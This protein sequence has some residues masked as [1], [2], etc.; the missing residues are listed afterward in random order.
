MVF[1]GRCKI[2]W[3]VSPNDRLNHRVQLKPKRR[4]GPL[5]YAAAAAAVPRDV[6][7]PPAPP[8]RPPPPPP[9][10]PS[11]S[12]SSFCSSFLVSS[13]QRNGIAFIDGH[14]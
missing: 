4:A 6:I 9:P 2:Q 3:P 8:P 5:L 7:R 11:S 13:H 10:P 12:S 1:S 14:E